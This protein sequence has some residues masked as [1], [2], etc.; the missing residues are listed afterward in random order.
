MSI[1]FLGILLCVELVCTFADAQQPPWR[2]LEGT[3]GNAGMAIEIHPKNPD[4]VYVLGDKYFMRTTDRGSTWD[5]LSFLGTDYA[6]LRTDPTNSQV[7]YASIP[8]L[9]IE[10]NDVY[11]S[12]DGG[13]TWRLS[14]IGRYFPTATIEVD[15]VDRRTV[16]AG[17]GPDKI[18]RTTDQGQTWDTVP[19]PSAYFLTS[20]AID[21][22]N[23]SILYAGYQSGVF[24]STDRG[25]SWIELQLGVPVGSTTLVAIDPCIPE[26]VYVAMWK[27]WV[28]PFARFF[29]STDG[30]LSW[31]ESD[32]GFTSSDIYIYALAINPKDPR[33]IFLGMGHVE[34][35]RMVLYSSNAGATWETLSDGLV[36][37]GGTTSLAID[38][39]NNRIYAG[40]GRNPDT[41]GV[42]VLDGVLT[43][44]DSIEQNNLPKEFSLFQNY[45]NPFNPETRIAFHVPS[46]DFVSLKVF[47]V[48]GRDVATI[49]E[50][51]LSPGK[52]TRLWNATGLP[53]GVY[54]YRLR[55]GQFASV[56]KMLL[57]R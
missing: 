30:G 21:P 27:N 31:Q 15:P 23:D 47:D 10:S 4:T 7:L 14:L 18:F 20:L 2:L 50:E 17:Q 49:I 51:S 37:V 33:Q 16:Y 5:S 26:N 38:T 1:R 13:Y 32:S 39:L 41:L 44:A 53:N 19:H 25:N 8:G 54:F 3:R 22:V 46:S 28:V 9:D 40:G 36:S 34:T 29:K 55:A 56:K 42:F 35:G 11:I 24:R 43:D 48:L 57:I 6:A 52:Y 45:P 12:S